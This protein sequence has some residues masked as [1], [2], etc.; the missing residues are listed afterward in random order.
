MPHFCKVAITTV[1]VA[2]AITIGTLAVGRVQAQTL[3]SGKITMIVAFAPGGVADTLARLIGKGWAKSACTRS[4]SKTAA[5]PVAISP[6]RPSR[7]RRPT[8]TRSWSPPPRWP[9]TRPCAEQGLL[10][11]A[12]SRRSRSPRRR[13]K[14]FVTGPGNPAA[15]LAELIK[16]ARGKSINFASA[17]VGSGSD[18][19]AE[20]FFKMLAKVPPSTCRSRAARRR[21]MPRSATRSI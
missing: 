3:P 6:P 14:R 18:I 19:E 20:Y 12:I 10:R 8:A 1:K 4:W 17:G 16:N 15:S 9:S 21:S 13:R 11:R 5:A 7:A 2:L